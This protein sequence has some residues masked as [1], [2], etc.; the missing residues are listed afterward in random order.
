MAKSP[1]RL[2]FFSCFKCWYQS[3]TSNSLLVLDFLAADGPLG[4]L[5]SVLEL[6]CSMS[7]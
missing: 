3:V 6:G 5:F 2:L 7:A 4:G 1:D